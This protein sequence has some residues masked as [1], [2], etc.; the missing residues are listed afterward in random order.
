[1]KA[2]VDAVYG[3]KVEVALYCTAFI[4]FHYPC[5][6]RF[7]GVLQVLP[8]FLSF[9]RINLLLLLPKF[10]VTLPIYLPLAFSILALQA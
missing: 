8:S 9:G 7:F 4:S 3:E 6:P 1:M 5:L 10:E 2:F